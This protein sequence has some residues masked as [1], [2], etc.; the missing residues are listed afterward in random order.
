MSVSYSFIQKDRV[1][2]PKEIDDL[3]SICMSVSFSSFQMDSV[4]G[5]D[6]IPGI[7]K[8]RGT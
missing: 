4:D 7:A 6:E 3:C 1:N 5:P 8:K 2:G